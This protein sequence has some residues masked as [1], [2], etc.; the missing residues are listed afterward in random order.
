MADALISLSL[1]IMSSHFEY[2]S[3]QNE[4][5]KN[6]LIPFSQIEQD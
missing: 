3:N 4:S 5:N 6:T 2:P 1:K